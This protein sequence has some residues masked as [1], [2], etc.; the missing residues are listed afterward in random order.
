MRACVFVYVYAC[1]RVCVCVCV[2]KYDVISTG[3]P[4][5]LIFR[6][7]SVLGFTINKTRGL[8]IQAIKSGYG[9]VFVIN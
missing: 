9:L 6:D 2:P 7:V 5:A 3:F 4:R 8:K 1:T